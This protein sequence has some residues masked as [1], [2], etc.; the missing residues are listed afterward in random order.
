M[1]ACIMAKKC[2]ICGE[3]NA[4]LH[5]CEGSRIG[6]GNDRNKVHHLGRE[7]MM[8]CEKHHAECHQDEYGFIERYHLQKVTLD[9]ALCK[10]LKLKK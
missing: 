2:C 7:A 8:L 3:N 9:E 6:A 10:R 5:H 4:H 1:Y